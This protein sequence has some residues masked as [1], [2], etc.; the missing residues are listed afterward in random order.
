MLA[1][2]LL[3]LMQ[4]VL[5]G[6]RQTRTWNYCHFAGDTDCDLLADAL[7]DDC[8]LCRRRS[9]LRDLLDEYSNKPKQH[10][11]A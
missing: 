9:G 1:A 6:H 10:C 8:E 3:L 7:H 5:A 4:P 2:V 11:A